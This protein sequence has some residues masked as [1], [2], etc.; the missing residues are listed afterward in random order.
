MFPYHYN[1]K[2]ENVKQERLGLYWVYIDSKTWKRCSVLFIALLKLKRICNFT[3]S[4]I[5][6]CNTL[7]RPLLTIVTKKVALSLEARSNWSWHHVSLALGTSACSRCWS[8]FAVNFQPGW[9][10][11]T[12]FTYAEEIT[13]CSSR[14]PPSQHLQGT[15]WRFEIH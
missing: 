6:T 14:P 10:L 1:Y 7:K 11:L 4:L 2:F 12:C 9:R 8:F 5:F 13:P 15:I 3:F